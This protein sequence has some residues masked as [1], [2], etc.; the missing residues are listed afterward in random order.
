[1]WSPDPQVVQYGPVGPQRYVG[2]Q[3]LCE[4]LPLAAAGDEAEALSLDGH[5][6]PLDVLLDVPEEEEGGRGSQTAGPLCILTGVTHH[7][8]RKVNDELRAALVEYQLTI[9]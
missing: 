5:A 1:M 7:R 3:T 6:R 8:E 4:G 2:S 9:P